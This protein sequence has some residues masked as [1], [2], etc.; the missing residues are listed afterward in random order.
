MAIRVT[1]DAYLDRLRS[2]ERYKPEGEQR[3][4][5]S[6]GELAEKAGISPVTMSRLANDHVKHLNLETLD[7]LMIVLRKYGFPV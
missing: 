3:Y 7:A 5:P 6:N 1:L 2:T 4:V